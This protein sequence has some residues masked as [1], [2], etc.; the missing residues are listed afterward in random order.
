MFVEK[1]RRVVENETE[2]PVV[3]VNIIRDY[4][5]VDPRQQLIDKYFGDNISATF[6]SQCYFCASQ[7]TSL[8][9]Y[10]PR[11]KTITSHS[12]LKTMQN[13]ETCRVCKNSVL[14]WIQSKDDKYSYSNCM[15]CMTNGQNY[16]NSMV[17]NDNEYLYA[18]RTCS[19][20][21]YRFDAKKDD[22]IC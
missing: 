4:T 5:L 10:T 1:W 11:I 6:T 15:D 2:L 20:I 8:F 14:K 9:I 12:L 22:D 16:K 13:Y 7:S 3:L 19:N 18:C 17:K 21:T